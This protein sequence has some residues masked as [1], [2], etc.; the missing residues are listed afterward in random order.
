MYTPY[1][2]QKGTP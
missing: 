2:I 1:Y